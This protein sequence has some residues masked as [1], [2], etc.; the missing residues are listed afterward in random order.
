MKTLMSIVVSGMVLVS[1]GWCVTAVGEV[2]VSQPLGQAGNMSRPSTLKN[3][4]L[5]FHD[6]LRVEK[7]YLAFAEKA[8]EEGYLSVANLFRAVALSESIHA[9]NHAAAVKSLGGSTDTSLVESVKIGS[10]KENLRVA[11]AVEMKEW[12]HIYPRYLA[13]AD[14]DN[15]MSPKRSFKYARASENQHAKFFEEALGSVESWRDGSRSFFVCQNCGYMTEKLPHNACA[16]CRFAKY[17]YKL[18]RS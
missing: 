18:V 7:M 8:K 11:I 13:Q 6:E 10:T 2:N 5:A 4:V 12:Q 15:I 16:E 17:Q 14:A 3:T 9:K 1:A